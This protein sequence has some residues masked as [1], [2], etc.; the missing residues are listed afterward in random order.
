MMNIKEVMSPWER[1]IGLLKLEKRDVRQVIYYA[2]FSGFLALTLPLGIQAI[3]NL[4]QGAQVSTSWI[5]LVILVTIGVAFVGILQ[6]M[7]MRIIETIQQR[8]FT[9]ASF[10]FTYRFPKFKMN[11]LRDNYPPELANR[12]FDTLNIQKGLAKILVDIPAAILQIVFALILLSFYH[13]FFIAFGFLLLI[14][15]FIVFKFTAKKGMDT[16]LME[17]KSKYKVAHWIQEVAR[18]V[19]SFKLSGKTNLA[20]SKNDELVN[21]YLIARESH[22]RILV[23][24]FIQMIGFKVVVTAGLLLIG[25]LLVLNQEMNIGQ[26]V[27]AEIIIL[28]V[29]ASVEKLILG[30]ESFYDVL[31]SLEKMGQIVDKELE[32]QDGDKPEFKDNFDIELDNV[33]FRVPNKEDDI[34]S[35]VSLKIKPKS[36]LLV[37]GESGAGKSSLL[38]LIAGVIEPTKGKVYLD[39]FML[40]NINLNHYRSHLGLSLADET[41]FE[42][43]IRE[44]ITFGN[45]EISDDQLMWA[46]ENVGLYQ[47]IKESPK[48]L[49]T[50]LYP[51]GRQI[52]YTIAKKIVLARAIVDKPKVLILEDP[53]DQFEPVEV[54]RIIK[55]LTDE[56]NPWALVVVSRNNDWS[57]SCTQVVTLK[58]G[59]I[60]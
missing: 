7:Q 13:P 39:K 49:N 21:D 60:I 8:I 38:R 29:I 56:S 4:I 18:A 54:K 16:S 46:I 1:L 32:I 11:E 24:Q 28:L 26:F 40:S 58:K 37:K 47:F 53:L 31:T 22:F 9:R 17:S 35:H 3:I 15:I 52:S 36:R 41:P 45:P 2:I 30:L 12:F 43:T 57:A 48:G 42:G 33:S 25:G 44:N 27:A 5:V 50:V 19:V 59:E 14:L 55:F 51:E 23:I 6:L 10:E 20:L 34:L